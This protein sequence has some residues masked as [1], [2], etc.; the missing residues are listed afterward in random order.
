MPAHVALP[1]VILLDTRL[2]SKP[3][4]PP[5]TAP[6][7]NLNTIIISL[8]LIHATVPWPEYTQCQ[9]PL[10]EGPLVLNKILADSKQAGESNDTDEEFVECIHFDQH[11]LGYDEEYHMG[12]ARRNKPVT[13][14]R[15]ILLRSF[16]FVPKNS[17]IPHLSLRMCIATKSYLC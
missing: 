2:T 4:T 15:N 8:E 5:M 11:S 9:R 1:L 12:K 16:A 7:I 13:T 6:S 3:T 10:S 17:G 14:R